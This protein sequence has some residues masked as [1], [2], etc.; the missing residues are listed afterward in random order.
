MIATKSNWIGVTVILGAMLLQ[1]SSAGQI[2]R[3]NTSPS[4]VEAVAPVYPP[5]ALRAA[6]RG[7]IEV[8]ATI[9]SN[10][11]VE[12]A[13]VISGPVLLRENCERTALRWKF[14]SAKDKET[15]LA[16]ILF[17]FAIASKGTPDDELTPIFRTPS[18]IEV[19]AIIPEGERS[20]D[21]T[22]IVKKPAR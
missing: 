12:S 10:G 15:R 2:K 8:Q 22:N 4:V 17:E 5:L 14:E 18:R 21:P 7:N 13:R 6:V 20:V 1:P 16:V 11:A 9:A 19:R 3:V